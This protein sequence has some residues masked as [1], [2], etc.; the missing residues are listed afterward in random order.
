MVAL[1]IPSAVEIRVASFIGIPIAICAAL[2]RIYLRVSS[3]KFWWDDFFALM[4]M[5][6]IAFLWTGIII[7][8]SPPENYSSKIKVFGYYLVDNGFY[9]TI[10]PA[11]ISILFT[12]IRLTYPGRFRQIL[13][14]TVGLFLLTWA[15]LDA[16]MWI[17]CETERGWK[18]KFVEQCM[19]G[20]K[21][22]AAQLATDCIADSGLIIISI[23]LFSS[24]TSKRYRSLKIRL[25]CIFSSTIFTTA[26]SLV[27]AYAIWYN[28]G[29]L[30]F[31]FAVIEMVVSLVV[32]NLTVLTSWLLRLNDDSESDQPSG[33]SDHINSFH[34]AKGDLNNIRVRG[35]TRR[36]SV[37]QELSLVIADMHRQIGSDAVHSRS[38]NSSLDGSR[39]T[40]PEVVTLRSS[41]T[42]NVLP[43]IKPFDEDLENGRLTGSIPWLGLESEQDQDC[44]AEEKE[45][46]EE[47]AGEV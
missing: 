9:A 23:Y 35:R 14:I 36:I 3:K 25:I 27:H 41:N 42:E 34:M 15:L 26:A 39:P 24:L 21:V 32:V 44:E 2:F 20:K 40:I 5:T 46:A 28:L 12:V 37:L 43:S 7:F 17:T 16:Q 47:K 33:P 30:E 13:K 31:M 18:N 4:S 45:K 8:T 29:Y 38:A 10:W 6:G 19:L 11:R 22:A 1:P